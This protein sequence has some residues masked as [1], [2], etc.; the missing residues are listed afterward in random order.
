MTRRTIRDKPDPT[1]VRTI[2]LL[3]SAITM[4]RPSIPKDEATRYAKVLNE[5]ASKNDFDP[6]IAVAMI[7]H[8]SRW[9]PS[10]ASDDGEDFGL[11]QIRARF[12]GA[13]KDD[14]DPV[15]AP[16]D[17]CKAVKAN[18]L[19][20]EHN[21]RAMGGIIA[22]NKKM[23]TQKRGSNK[24]DFW[25]AGYQ[26]LSQP[27]RNKWCTPGPTTTRVLDYHKELVAQLLPAPRSAKN[28]AIAKAGAK[29]TTP[30][31]GTAATPTKPGTAAKP[32]PATA[33]KTPTKVTPAKVTPTKP[34]PAKSTAAKAAPA[35]SASK[36]AKPHAKSKPA[37]IR[38]R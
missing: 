36:P 22:A 25:I 16:S 32:T 23:C 2:A 11:G 30:A 29:A 33:A 9:L 5:I 21:L 26:G 3:I 10:I 8:E 37:P 19:T 6:L 34:S 7:H 14:E 20:G 17:A 27:E 18:L 24:A 31:K 1:L 35:K 4:S 13:C 15:H 28:T 38:V 12:I